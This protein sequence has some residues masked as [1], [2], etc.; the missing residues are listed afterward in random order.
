[1]IEYKSKLLS[2]VKG[3]SYN[4]GSKSTEPVKRDIFTLNQVHS[5][6][7]IFLKNTR[8]LHESIDGDAIVT[9]QKGF[10]IG[11]KTA[12]CVPI[13]LTDINA[14]F[15]AAIHSG[16]RG[17]YHKIIINTLDL[18]FKKLK[19]NARDIVGSIGP[20]ISLPNY[21]VSK[22]MWIKFQKKFNDSSTFLKEKNNKFFM[23]LSRINIS[24]LKSSGVT[25]IDTIDECT[26]FNNDFYSYRRDKSLSANQISNIMLN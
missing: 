7:V 1:L 5:N 16:W 10:N 17:T 26:Y 21:E 22:D 11:V 2:S 15:V 6:K 18:I 25:K 24:L 8:G 4:F 14:T 13:L 9:T 23:D 20:S 19:I 12:D 3:I